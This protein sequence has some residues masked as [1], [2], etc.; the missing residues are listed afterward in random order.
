[1]SKHH[2]VDIPEPSVVFAD[3][4]FEAPP[5]AQDIGVD[6]PFDEQFN[7]PPGLEA[8]PITITKHWNRFCSDILQN[9]RNMKGN[10]LAPSYC[11]LS[12]DECLH[13]TDNKRV[14]PM[15]WLEAFDLFFLPPGT[16]PHLQ[17]QNYPSM[18]YRIEWVDMKHDKPANV[19]DVIRKKYWSLFKELYW[20]PKPYKDRL[21]KYTTDDN[22]ITLPSTL[23]SSAPHIIINPS[24][25]VPTWDPKH[26]SRGDHQEAEEEEEEE[27]EVIDP[28]YVPAAKWVSNIL[29]IPMH[30]YMRQEEE[31]SESD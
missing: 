16:P 13:V 28:D 4:N 29:P 31:E 20:V 15:E 17:P 8:F 5:P 25:L 18:T 19:I 26:V 27:A 7:L 11:R 30:I 2:R 6:L 3:L 24:K 9:Y 21:W 14:H 12:M 22:F 1:M 23:Q 10:P